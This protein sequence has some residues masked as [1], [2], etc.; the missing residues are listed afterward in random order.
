MKTN[1][2]LQLECF[3]GLISIGKILSNI[4]MPRAIDYFEFYSTPQYITKT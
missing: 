1:R 3:I 4:C 2:D